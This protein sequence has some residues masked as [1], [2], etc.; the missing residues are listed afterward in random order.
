MS[1]DYF[2]IKWSSAIGMWNPLPIQNKKQ[3][4]LEYLKAFLFI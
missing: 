1:F 2:P 4:S 3:K